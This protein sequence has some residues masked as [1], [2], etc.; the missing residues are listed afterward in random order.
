MRPFL[1]KALK[2]YWFVG[3]RSSLPAGRQDRQKP[4]KKATLKAFPKALKFGKIYG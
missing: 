1:R 3:Q 2:V 4:I